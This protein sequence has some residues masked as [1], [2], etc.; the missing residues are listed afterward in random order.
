MEEQTRVLEV[1]ELAQRETPFCGACG[2]PTLPVARGGSLWLECASAQEDRPFLR[3]LLS[4]E[5]AAGHTRRVI[6]E[7]AA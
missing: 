1:L 6:L 2:S 5:F 4:L 3:R 7:D